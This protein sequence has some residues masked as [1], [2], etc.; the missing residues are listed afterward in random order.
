MFRHVSSLDIQ[1]L[2]TACRQPNKLLY[3][4]ASYSRKQEII[5]K[6]PFTEE[7]LGK[8]AMGPARTP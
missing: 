8:K 4:N 7:S 5:A 1:Q 2:V 6:P 3:S